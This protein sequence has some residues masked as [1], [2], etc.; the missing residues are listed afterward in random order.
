M[1]FIDGE[2]LVARFQAMIDAGRVRDDAVAYQK[3][4]FVWARG[5]LR[6][7]VD[8]YDV[9]RVTYY[10]SVLGDESRID[11]IER[12]IGGQEYVLHGGAGSL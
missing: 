2:N 6:R 11:E 3:D 4:V 8:G 1:V 10:T 9:I 5:C 7:Y 12:F